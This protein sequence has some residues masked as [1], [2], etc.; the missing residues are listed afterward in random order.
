MNGHRQAQQGTAWIEAAL[1]LQDF[2]A[3]LSRIAADTASSL[4][5][6]ESGGAVFLSSQDSDFI[7]NVETY[8]LQELFRYYEVERI[9]D[10][11]T[12]LGHLIT[13]K[14]A[15]SPALRKSAALAIK[16]H[17][18]RRRSSA[19]RQMSIES[20]ILQ[21]LLTRHT[22]LRKILEEFDGKI[23]PLEQNSLVAVIS[24]RKRHSGR[25]RLENRAL[26]S[27]EEKFSR[28]FRRYMSW[29]EKQRLVIAI[30]PQFPMDGNAAV[31]FIVQ[32][33]ENLKAA[34][35]ENESFADI[36]MGVGT[37][38]EDLHMLPESYDEAT[39]AFHVAVLDRQN[40][41]RRW[42][43]LGSYRLLTIFAEHPEADLFI[44]NTLGELARKNLP[45]EHLILLDTI[46]ELDRCAWNLKQT[47]VSMGLHYNT[48]KYRYCRIQEVLGVSL[49]DAHTRFNLSF[50]VKLL[51]MKG[52]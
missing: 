33:I 31:D 24:F 43:G 47:S 21:R 39:R 3:L 35:A 32:T 29:Q 42:D 4:C 26:A 8:P 1:N 22:K 10:N 11:D 41:W 20:D 17:A 7:E 49:G 13:T 37:C 28:F 2:E 46:R 23:F 9:T 12:L 45:A 18:I 6:R 48:L 44:E 34:C 5:F 16:I 50:A 27:L 51:A 15:T 14:A 40:W 38:K 30:T 52:R 25:T 19:E 36:C